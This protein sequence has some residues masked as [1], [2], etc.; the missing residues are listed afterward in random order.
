MWQN[1][2]EKYGLSSR[3]WVQ[4]GFHGAIAILYTKQVQQGTL[5]IG[6]ALAKFSYTLS[7]LPVWKDNQKYQAL[8]KTVLDTVPGIR[9]DYYTA[10]YLFARYQKRTLK[11]VFEAEL[12]LIIPGTL[13]TVI[14]SWQPRGSLVHAIRTKC[15]YEKKRMSFK[16]D[17][18]IPTIAGTNSVGYKN[19]MLREITGKVEVGYSFKLNGGTIKIVVGYESD[20][21]ALNFPMLLKKEQNEEKQKRGTWHAPTFGIRLENFMKSK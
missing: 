12:N 16:A 8:S 21:H 6:P 14:A 19:L 7:G 9:G 1:A 18:Q 10:L 20:W 13:P 5:S 17:I 4:G 2:A 3:S 11:S 15:I